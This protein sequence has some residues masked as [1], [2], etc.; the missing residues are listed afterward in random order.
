MKKIGLAKL[1]GRRP[2]PLFIG[3]IPPLFYMQPIYFDQEKKSDKCAI[4][5]SDDL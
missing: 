4:T 5:E 1:I 3:N 2:W